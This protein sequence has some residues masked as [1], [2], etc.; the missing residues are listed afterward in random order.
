MPLS[1][2][3]LMT[4]TFGGRRWKA[5]LQFQ[6]GNDPNPTLNRNTRPE[7]LVEIETDNVGRIA[8]SLTLFSGCP[9]ASVPP[10]REVVFL[11][12]REGERV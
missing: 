1:G 11:R 5:D 12:S 4:L 9:E 7:A 2:R 10:V 8:G 3:S 6:P